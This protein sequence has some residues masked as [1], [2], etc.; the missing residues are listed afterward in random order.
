MPKNRIHKSKKD[1]RYLYYVTDSQGKRRQLKS[2]KNESSG[3]F[4]ARCDALDK[5]AEG[6]STKDTMDDLFYLWIENHVKVHLSPAELRVQVPVYENH[7]RPFIGHRKL[8]DIKR[9]DVYTVLSTASKAGLSSSFVKKIRGAISR[10][11]NWAINTLGY[12]LVAPTQGLVFRATS[13]DEAADVEKRSRIISDEDMERIMKAASRSKYF[14]YFKILASTGL[15]PSEALGLQIRDIKDDFLEIRRGWTIDGY[16]PLKTKAAKRDIPLTTDLKCILLDQREKYAFVTKE[17]WLFPAANKK[18]SMNA[19][20]CAFKHILKQTAEW[21]KGGK[22]NQKKIAII[23]PPVK[24]SLYD[25]RHTFATRMAEAGMHQTALQ[26]IMGHTDI[27]IT[28]KYYI[29]VTDNM[30]EQARTLMS[31]Q[32]V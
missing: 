20:Q 13:D 29:G 7:V 10:P 27:S 3:S 26:A 8:T 12:E 24:C 4:R 1:G 22:T 6:P 23:R 17:G 15:R 16:S 19:L 21:K 25:F 14:N 32:N 11:Y 30:M 28:L 9:A 2:R 5:E 18:P 31:A